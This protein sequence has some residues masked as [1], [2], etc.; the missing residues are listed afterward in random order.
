MSNADS[1]KGL[2]R[3]LMPSPADH[4]W[5]GVDSRVAWR[6]KLSSGN[7]Q[8]QLETLVEMAEH[9]NV[10]GVC[11]LV[12]GFAGS[13]IDAHRAAAANALE[14]SVQPTS[15]ETKALIKGLAD[16]SDG[17]IS[18]WSATLLGRLG[19]QALEATG[20]LCDCLQKSAFLP[21]RERA[22][23]ALL[24]IGPSAS[25]AIPVLRSVSE[26]APARLRKL[27]QNAIEEIGGGVSA[28]GQRAA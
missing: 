14:R 2:L 28:V 23:W 19:Q 16:V 6:K 10:S 20:A 7:C 27:C 21:A 15:V 11:E 22:A 5:S 1:E 4:D 24:K 25:D 12:I 13:R 18:Y 3:G 17:E 8:V 26:A 9:T